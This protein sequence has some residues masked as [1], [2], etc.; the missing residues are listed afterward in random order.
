MER[1]SQHDEVVQM[2]PYRMVLLQI[3]RYDS[4]SRNHDSETRCRYPAVD[5]L[6]HAR[7]TAW[8][9]WVAF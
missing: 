7:A 5:H 4:T 6:W 9:T 3:A 1:A 8:V 2:E